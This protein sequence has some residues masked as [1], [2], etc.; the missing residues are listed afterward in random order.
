MTPTAFPHRS[1]SVPDRSPRDTSGTVP[2]FPPVG[3]NGH[4]HR[5]LFPPPSP[6]REVTL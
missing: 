6:D 1:R 4:S 3:G 2:R 5:F